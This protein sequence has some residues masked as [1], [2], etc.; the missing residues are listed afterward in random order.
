MVNKAK[1]GDKINITDFNFKAKLNDDVSGDAVSLWNDAFTY[2]EPLVELK[3]SSNEL[4]FL[5]D[6]YKRFLND[7]DAKALDDVIR[8]NNIDK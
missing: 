8:R 6:T 1:W 5:L 7:T 4:P 3:K 2:L